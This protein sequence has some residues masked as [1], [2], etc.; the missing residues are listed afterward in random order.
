METGVAEKRASIFNYGLI[1]MTVTH[2]LTHVFQRIHLALFPILREE[3]DLSLQQLGVIAAIPFLC[4]AILAIPTGVLSDRFGSKKLILVSL[5]VAVFGSLMAS[6]TLNP[7]MLTVAVSLVYINTVI[8]H[9][10]SYS[11]TTRLFKSRDRSKALG[12]HGAGGTFGMA[13]GPISVSVL[14]ALFAFGW[15]QVY[16][17]WVVPLFI[18][19]MMILRLKSE[20]TDDAKDDAKTEAKPMIQRKSLFTLSLVMFL[21]FVAVRNT[22]VQ[23]IETFFTVYLEDQRGLNEI[24]ASLIY[25]GSSL[26]GIVAAPLGGVVAAKVGEKKWVLIS[27]S[28]AYVSLGLAVVVPNIAIFTT[29]YLTYGFFNTLSM[30]A[31]SAIMAHLSPS[32]QRGLGYA[33]YFLPSEIM[34]VLS[35]IIAAFVAAAFG[36]TS[37]FTVALAIFVAGLVVLRLGVKV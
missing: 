5:A 24:L 34:G 19:V 33:L 4:Q 11:F 6:Q 9:P 26:V 21:V 16:L 30:A 25:G 7:I 13:I 29:L 37:I 31:N 10:A 27:L 18:G 32:R 17:F 2:M 3:F 14:M 12:V 8:Y 1:A 35:P 20:P 28:I 15:R 23:M 36:L 22:A